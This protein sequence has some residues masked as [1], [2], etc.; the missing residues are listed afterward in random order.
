MMLEDLPNCQ[1]VKDLRA[2]KRATKVATSQHE[3]D[4]LLHDADEDTAGPCVVMKDCIDHGR[5]LFVEDM[6]TCLDLNEAKLPTHLAF[7]ALMNPI[8]GRKKVVVGSGLMA[9]SQCEATH[10]GMTRELQSTKE[11]TAGAPMAIDVSE[12]ARS[13]NSDD[14]SSDDCD[15]VSPH[16]TAAACEMKQLNKA[17]RKECR[18]KHAADSRALFMDKGNGPEATIVLGEPTEPGDN[19]SAGNNLFDCLGSSGK[20]DLLDSTLI[21]KNA[22]REHAQ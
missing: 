18:P 20:F 6:E 17:K 15:E 16:C 22:G 21:A 2:R 3:R 7:G 10:N 11:E 8:I 14:G 5:K 13:Q 9:D 19:L 12:T 4:L 1:S